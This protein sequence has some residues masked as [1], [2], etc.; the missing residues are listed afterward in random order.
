MAAFPCIFP[1]IAITT[2]AVHKQVGM[3]APYGA[4]PLAAMTAAGSACGH[5][6]SAMALPSMRA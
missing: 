3:R 5:S 6:G 2:G 4:A 1:V